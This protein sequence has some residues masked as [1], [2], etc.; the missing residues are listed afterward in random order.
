[1][2]IA[3]I[4]LGKNQQEAVDCMQEHNLTPFFAL[5]QAIYSLLLALA[6]FFTFE[7]E[8]RHLI[9]ANLSKSSY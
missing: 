2:P 3:L 7:A 1:M 8:T 5:L 9:S 6:A 4:S